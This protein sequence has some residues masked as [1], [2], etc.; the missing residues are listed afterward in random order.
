[1]KTLINNF[2]QCWRD[3]FDMILLRRKEFS[4]DNRET[5]PEDIMSKVEKSGVIQQDREGRWRIIN[6]DKKKFWTAKYKSKESAE[7]GLRGYFASKR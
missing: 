5:V 6:K 1:M 7:A 3:Y 2:N 4:I